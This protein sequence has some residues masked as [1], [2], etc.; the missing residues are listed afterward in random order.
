MS[1]TP[2]MIQ[3]HIARRRADVTEFLVLL[4]SSSLKIAP[5]VWQVVTGGIEEGELAKDAALREM[6]EET[7][8]T[9]LVMWELPYLASFFSERQKEMIHVPVYAA[10][11]N[12]N[13]EVVISDEHQSYEW[14]TFGDALGRLVFP[15]HKEGTEYVNT[16]IMNTS[17][18]VPF[19]IVTRNIKKA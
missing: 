14:L 16:H 2:R 5:N 9:P 8:L 11:V 10:I 17:G 13:D 18:E 4:R 19:A 7:G 3:L 6:N 12:E 1:Y 15:S